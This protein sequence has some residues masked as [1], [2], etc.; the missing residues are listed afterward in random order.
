ME[1]IHTV[2]RADELINKSYQ[3]ELD[4]LT[5]LAKLDVHD[6]DF[7]KKKEDIEVALDKKKLETKE[8]QRI[9]EQLHNLFK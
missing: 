4:L 2:Q 5:I 1:W 6:E 3:E 8:L 7:D 9:R